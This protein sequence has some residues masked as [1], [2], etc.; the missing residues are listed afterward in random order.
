MTLAT[1]KLR[2][3]ENPLIKIVHDSA[4]GRPPANHVVVA[5]GPASCLVT[6]GVL[7]LPSSGCGQQTYLL[8]AT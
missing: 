4:H 8:L 3:A 7:V 6:H 1:S 2:V 5:D